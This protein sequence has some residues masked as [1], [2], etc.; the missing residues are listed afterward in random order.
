MVL[1]SA[2]LVLSNT[3]FT[4]INVSQDTIFCEIVIKHQ[5]LPKKHAYLISLG[6]TITNNVINIINYFI[7]YTVIFLGAINTLSQL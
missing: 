6:A 1:N 7:S 4:R 3:V 2:I 5:F